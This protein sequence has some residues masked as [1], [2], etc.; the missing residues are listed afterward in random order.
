MSQPHPGATEQQAWESMFSH[1]HFRNS[2]GGQGWGALDFLPEPQGFLKPSEPCAS[3]APPSGTTTSTKNSEPR[4]R[5]E[6]LA[7]NPR[8]ASAAQSFAGRP[9]AQHS[10]PS[11]PLPVTGA[12]RKDWC[13]SSARTDGQV[14]S[15][16]PVPKP[17][18]T[19]ME[20]SGPRG[21]VP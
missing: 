21:A 10:T 5:G 3:G 11:Q 18:F 12:S 15:R 7:L 19:R 14:E 4:F 17:C 16:S 1:L 9:G 2:Q 6:C 20:T 13:A 8:F